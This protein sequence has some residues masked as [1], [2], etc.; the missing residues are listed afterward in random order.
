M[1]N[2]TKTKDRITFTS[3]NSFFINT[4]G[5]ITIDSFEFKQTSDGNFIEVVKRQMPIELP[6]NPQTTW[7]PRPTNI[8]IVWKEIYGVTTDGTGTRNLQLI[9]SIEGKVTPA[10]HVDEKIQFE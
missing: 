10:H 5:E 4:V 2:I 7:P 6:M 8:P 9:Q 1:E 3:T